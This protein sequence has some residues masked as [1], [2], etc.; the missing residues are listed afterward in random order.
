MVILCG[1]HS[2]VFAL[3]H[4][5]FWKI[6]K[7]EQDLRKITVVNRAII[8]I[9]NLQLIYLFFFVTYVCFF[10]TND[11]MNTRLGNILLAGM[12]L[13]WLGRTI[14]QFIFFPVT[15]RFVNILTVLFITGIILFVLPLM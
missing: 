4:S 9:A 6:F 1:I 2:L 5:F 12:A 11:L 14:Q 7:W 15:N 8:Q 13:F 3:F 10:H